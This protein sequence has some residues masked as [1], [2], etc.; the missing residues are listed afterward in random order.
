MRTI[1]LAI[2]RVVYL[3]LLLIF[4]AACATPEESD[5][6]S[7]VTPAPPAA[8]SPA[9]ATAEPGAQTTPEF[10]IPATSTPAR[11]TLIIWL[12]PAIASRTETGAVTLSDHLL[13]FNSAYPG[14]EIIVEQKATGGQ[15]G[16]LNYL[17]TGRAVA[18]SILPDLIA[19]PVTQLAVTASEGLIFP[20]EEFLDPALVDDLFPLAQEWAWSGDHLVGFPFALTEVLH[21]EYSAL[22]TDSVPL[23]WTEFI[24]DTTR[25]MVF[26][27][28]GP[29]GGRLA[30]QLYLAAGGS[31][32]NEAGQQ[33]LEEEPLVLA[34]E[35]LYNGRLNGFILPQ[36]SNI[37]TLPDSVRLVRDGVAEYSLTSSDVFL[38][39]VST[40]YTPRFAAVPGYQEALPALTNGWAWAMTTSDPVKKALV[41][42]L[43]TLLTSPERLGRWS[44][45]SQVVPSHPDALTYWPE[46][47]VYAPFIRTELQQAIPMPLTATSLILTVLENAVFDV[48]SLAKSPAVAAAEAIAALQ[49]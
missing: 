36:S 33:V 39:S 27:A 5:S 41:A 21:L 40:G 23:T 43:I 12:P 30:L 1:F 11:Q 42:E 6:A 45:H 4:L 18:P 34:L 20:M 29:A 31:L 38:Q 3:P 46:E 26:P 35:Q 22:I 47:D 24:S 48:I 14:L 37:T 7:A 28:A 10:I 25:Q 13:T 49:P 17:R 9:V 2:I 19:L 32:T 15:G 16:T 44:W 8:A